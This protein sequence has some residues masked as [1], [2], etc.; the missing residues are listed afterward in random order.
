MGPEC[1]DPSWPLIA[2]YLPSWQI[3][4]NCLLNTSD[5]FPSLRDLDSCAVAMEW[6]PLESNLVSIQH[7]AQ[8]E[9]GQCQLSA[10]KFNSRASAPDSVCSGSTWCIWFVISNADPC[11]VR[12][13]VHVQMTLLLHRFGIRKYRRTCFEWECLIF[14]IA[15]IR[16]DLCSQLCQNN[17]LL[18]SSL[19]VNLCNLILW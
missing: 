1:D 15:G 19:L 17:S 14:W 3:W 11:V 5:Y 12:S 4:V 16:N 10:R 13:V 8:I 7:P 2:M 6:L 9:L 18:E